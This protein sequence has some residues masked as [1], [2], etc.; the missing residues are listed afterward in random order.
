MYAPNNYLQ[1]MEMKTDRAEGIIGIF[2]ILVQ[3]LQ[4]SSLSNL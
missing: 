1:N 3:G 4:Y 2:I